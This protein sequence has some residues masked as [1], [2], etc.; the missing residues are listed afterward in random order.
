MNFGVSVEAT[1]RDGVSLE[2][3][4][5]DGDQL[6]QLAVPGS[7]A[8]CVLDAFGPAQG[9]AG[10]RV[11]VADWLRCTPHLE[12]QNVWVI[13]AVEDRTYACRWDGNACVDTSPGITIGLA[14]VPKGTELKLV[15]SAKD[16]ADGDTTLDVKGYNYG[17]AVTEKSATR[18]G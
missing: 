16:L 8:R 17:V 12:R 18:I 10:V 1:S 13:D 2:F 5:S 7:G 11:F 9:A 3:D 6:L 14:A 4:D 15:N